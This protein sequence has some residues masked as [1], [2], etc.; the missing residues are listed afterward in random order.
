DNEELFTTASIGI[1][2]SPTGYDRQEDVLRDADIAMYRAKARGKARHEVFDKTMHDRAVKLLQL[3]TA[4]RRA[5]DRDELRVHYQPIVSL[6][7]GKIIGFEALLR[8]QRGEEL[9]SA[10]E[11]VP[12]AEE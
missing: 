4:L 11:I 12:V 1:A 6:L 10:E 7:N 9:I 8:W 5:V 2:L 3:E